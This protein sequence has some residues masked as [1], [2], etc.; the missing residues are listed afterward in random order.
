MTPIRRTELWFAVFGLLLTP[1]LCA[2]TTSTSPPTFTSSTDLVLIP[3]VV[4][5]SGAHLAGLKKEDFVL[6]QD[7]KPQPIAIFEEVKTDTARVRRS[8]G[9]HGTFSNVE[10]GANVS[11]YHRLSIIVLDFVNTPSADQANARTALVKFLSEVAESGEPMC[12]MVLTSS[13]LTVLHDFTDDPRLLAEALTKAKSGAAPLI[14]EPTV[15]PHHPTGGPL[16]G[17]I[18]AMIRGHMMGETQMASL[19]TKLAA[20]ITVQALQQIAKAFRGFPGRKSLIWASSGFP[21][22]LSSSA[23]GLCEPSCP[24]IQGRKEMQSAYDNLWRLMNDAQIAIYSVD[25]RLAT[26]GTMMT[27]GGVRPSDTGDPQFDTDAQAHQA[28]EDT[29]STLRLFAENTGGKAFM[30]GSNLVQS[31]HQAI[32][33]DSSY[34]ML[35]YYVSSGSAKPGWHDVSLT[36]RAKGAHTRY[37]N[38]FLLSRD[39]STTSARDDIQLALRSPLDYTGVPM[40]V[41]WTGRRPG[42][43]SGK[44]RVQFDLVLPAKFASVDQSDTNHMVVDVA[45]VARNPKGDVVADLSQRIDAHLDAAGLEQIEHNGMTYHNGI[46]L[47]PGEYNVRFVVRDALGN[48][49]GSLAAPVKVVP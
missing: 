47:P 21:F 33:D 8:E 4:S 7:G 15:D 31:F 6:K 13:G 3:A 19:E 27:T 29:G 12:L 40:S 14:Y 35:G 30:G 41:T 46:Q 48:R 22:T 49:M 43:D 28:I 44:T 1:L 38:A 5:K 39:T 26:A 23:P 37:R 20:S 45:A 34:Y 16:A 9:E 18:T 42:K 2:Q 36:V 24:G 10:P 25:L 32:Q 11:N 17:V